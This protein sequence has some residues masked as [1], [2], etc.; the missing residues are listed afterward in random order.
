MRL[1]RRNCKLCVENLEDRTVP[2][3]ACVDPPAGLVSWWPGDGHAN[4]IVDANHGSMM[5]GA[6]F[7][8]GYIEQAFS[9]DGAND[10][11]HIPDASNLT[12]S[13]L[14]LEAWVKPD[15]IS[16]SRVIV[17]KYQSSD[18][19]PNRFSWAL[20]N[21]DGRIRFGVYQ[22][23]DGP[24]R[25]V[26]TDSPVLIAGVWQH[27]VGTFDVATQ[28]I[29]VFR[30]GAQI[31]SS[32]VPGHDG[33]V[34]NISDSPSP[35]R[36]GSVVGGNGV[37][38]D[39][40]DGLIDEVGLYGQALSAT[41]IQSIYS[42][43]SAGKCKESVDLTPTHLA[44]N[45]AQG[46]VDFAYAVTGGDLPMDTSAMLWWV[47]DT[48][49]RS[50]ALATPIPIPA[51]SG[52]PGINHVPAADLLPVAPGA[53]RLL[54]E[55]DPDDVI[56]E[57]VED[58]NELEIAIPDI[59][60]HSITTHDSRSVSIDYEVLNAAVTS[61]PIRIH[62]SEGP[63]IDDNDPLLLEKTVP[64]AMGR[65]TQT[66]ALPEPLHIDPSHPYIIAKADPGNLLIETAEDNNSGLF[67]KFVLGVVT[68][69]F[70]PPATFP[71]WVGAVEN[72][73]EAS[74]GRIGYDAVVPYYWVAD[75]RAWRSGRT[76]YHGQLLAG[77]VRG[78]GL[79][80]AN[81]SEFTPGRDVVDV[82]FIG[83]S[84]GSVVISQA[85]QNLVSNPGVE[86]LNSGFKKMTMLDPHPAHNHL[87]NPQY[88]VMPGRLGQ[89]AEA[90]LVLFQAVASDPEVHVPRN[91]HES[92]VF[93]QQTPWFAT[94]NFETVLNLWGEVPVLNL[95]GQPVHYCDLT[96]VGMS[97][98]VVPTW[99][100]RNV[101]PSLWRGESFHCPSGG[102]V[103]GDLNAGN[104]NDNLPPAGS[105]PIPVRP[106]LP[107]LPGFP[108]LGAPASSRPFGLL[109]TPAT[110]GVV[111]R[112]VPSRS[113]RVVQTQS[114]GL[115]N[116]FSDSPRRASTNGI[117][118][119][120]ALL[121]S[122]EEL[123]SDWLAN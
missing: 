18:Q 112:D 91:V 106:P 89:V 78:E 92:E 27:V 123:L 107:F 102:S 35:V 83:H 6:S 80:L 20:A 9:L 15:T 5:N 61:V 34:T 119:L 42:A 118:R 77:V 22:H 120:F 11:I 17:S 117:D 4:D 57:A 103:S 33:I 56:D 12:P 47:T 72:V 95:S 49:V 13:S 36:I 90:V 100:L 65:Q 116:R 99:Y 108:P 74:P 97:H 21:L 16:G 70:T 84:R 82:H 53:T 113:P 45:P 7:A 121:A 31:P 26:D 85:L 75:S 39:F 67:R 60:I 88:S 2:S 37:M 114:G 50:P 98:T 110:A 69:G 115:E 58:N 59:V 19:I 122:E 81:K 43:G 40:W 93:F 23:A 101:A 76:E 8:P 52:T 30:N 46:G 55:L 10:F 79:K 68:H 94:L 104:N 105:I 86:A 3:G 41:E 29:K 44:W 28:A 32:F 111:R 48:G 24:Y 54:L 96:G 25:V 109:G 14:S 73:I 62:R 51:P 71:D 1:R 66:L 87:L 64:G 38:V 63:L